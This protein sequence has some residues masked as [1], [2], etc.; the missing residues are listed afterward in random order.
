M[1]DAGA[2]LPRTPTP[3]PPPQG[4]RSSRTRQGIS[5]D[6]DPDNA[7][8]V[9]TVVGKS[10]ASLQS[11]SVP[12]SRSLWEPQAAGGK[13]AGARGRPSPLNPPESPLCTEGARR[14][15]WLPCAAGTWAGGRCHAHG[16]VSSA[17]LGRR[18]RGHCQLGRL[19]SSVLGLLWE[20]AERAWA[21]VSPPSLGEAAASC[22]LLPLLS[23]TVLTYSEHIPD[24]V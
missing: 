1:Q 7:S 13:A 18:R 9:S 2:R 16:P 11:G 15:R 5:C 3:G 4:C 14:G 8:G 21:W 10:L 17:I 24:S 12:D 23:L 22:Q 6:L 19:S 20:G